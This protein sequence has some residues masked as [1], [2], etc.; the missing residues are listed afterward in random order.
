SFVTIQFNAA[1]G[2]SPV[3]IFDGQGRILYSEPVSEGDGITTLDLSE[4]PNGL[5]SIT[6]RGESGFSVRQVAV[7][8]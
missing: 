7:Q 3:D 5:Y 1:R 2:V 6:L 8:R 4:F